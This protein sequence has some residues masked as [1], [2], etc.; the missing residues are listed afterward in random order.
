MTS[1]FIH[2]VQKIQLTYDVY[3][4]IYKTQETVNILP[5]QFLLCETNETNPRLRRA[6]SVSFSDG[7][8]IHFIIKRLADGKGG[9]KAIC[10]QEIGHMM[11][12]W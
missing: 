9:S 1:F 10:D 2:L 12:V 6:Y 3:E 11:Q 8:N 5:G 7:E 4:L